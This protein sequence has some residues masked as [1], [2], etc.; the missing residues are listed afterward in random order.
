M[1]NRAEDIVETNT[2]SETTPEVSLQKSFLYSRPDSTPADSTLYIQQ[3]V[4]DDIKQFTVVGV[5]I[6][7][8]KDHSNQ[9]WSTLNVDREKTFLDPNNPTILIKSVAIFCDTL[10]IVD[11]LSLP[12][13]DIT[14]YA[15]Q[16]IL[17]KSQAINTS[18]LKWASLPPIVDASA[19]SPASN[20]LNGRNAGSFK[21]FTSTITPSS[22][23]DKYFVALGS[24][25]QNPG[26]GKDGADG[27]SA[28]YLSEKYFRRQALFGVDKGTAHFNPPAIKLKY[29]WISLNFEYDDNHTE[30]DEA[31]PENGT[32][33]LA[34]GIPGNGGNGGGLITN[35]Q[36]IQFSLDNSGGKPGITPRD[37]NG[38][39]AGTPMSWGKYYLE[40]RTSATKYD[41]DFNYQLQGSGITRAGAPATGKTASVGSTPKPEIISQAKNAW[42]HPLALQKV[43]EYSRDLFLAGEY[44]GSY[45]PLKELLEEYNVALGE[46]IQNSDVWQ[47]DQNALWAAA[48]TEIATM[49]SRLNS[50]LDYFGHPAG[51][52]PLLSL[53]AAMTMYENET[54]RALRILLLSSWFEATEKNLNK[55]RKAI[56]EAMDGLEKEIADSITKVETCTTKIND[57]L[58]QYDNDLKPQLDNKALQL[59]TLKN[60]LL[61]DATLDE[62]AKLAVKT[63]VQIAAAVCQAIPVGQPALGIAGGISGEVLITLMGNDINVIDTGSKIYSVIKGTLDAK[64]AADKALEEAKKKKRPTATK[65]AKE[66]SSSLGTVA[67]CV[68]ATFSPISEIVK[69]LQVPKAEIE[70]HLQKLES[71]SR[72]WKGLTDEIRLL[73]EQKVKLFAAL[74]EASQSLTEAWSSI[75]SSTS[76]YVSLYQDRLA[77][78]GKLDPAA[79]AFVGNMTQ[80]SRLTLLKYLYFMVKSYETTIFETIQVDWKLDTITKKIS[81]LIKDSSTSSELNLESGV[82]TLK[83]VFSE[84]LERVRKTLLEKF[85]A[86]EKNLTTFM[87]LNAKQTQEFIDQ[88]NIGRS[89]TIDPLKFS[90]VPSRVQMSKLVDIV[91]E[92]VEFE[93]DGPGLEDS[94]YFIVSVKA[95]NSGAIRK[96]SNIYSVYSDNPATWLW[97]I[98]ANEIIPALP[99]KASEDVLDFVIGKGADIIR[100][101]IAHQ[102]LWSDLTIN[103]SYFPA[104]SGKKRPCI[105]RLKF[106]LS[107]DTQL[108]DDDQC[109]LVVRST[110]AR[111]GAVISCSEDLGGRK[112]G[113]DPL[114][115]IYGINTKV[116]LEAPK[117][118][119]GSK[120][121]AWVIGEGT[122]ITDNPVSIELKESGIAECQWCAAGELARLYT[123]AVVSFL[124]IRLECSRQSEVVGFAPSIQETEI[125]EEGS[126]GWKHVHYQGAT[127]WILGKD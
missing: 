59:E 56:T 113:Y 9:L 112:A 45:M 83:S 66:N 114:V 32:D 104:Q 70:A 125:L 108:S 52:A 11:G 96:G 58:R 67:Q 2:F 44:S 101:K 16:I 75:T 25:G 92:K 23:S 105:K 14:I 10:E 107:S 64:K 103:I 7:I 77:N 51:Y 99:S 94:D 65:S 26:A 8:Q 42:L 93:S 41:I 3:F 98:S 102:P 47:N 48:K 115:R 82:N 123:D 34:P 5:H 30:L 22:S 100:S 71:E 4:D 106:K 19:S 117:E 79:S 73:N 29:Q 31:P 13:A 35:Q 116:K 95:G 27:R 80:R 119:G 120:F 78:A 110:G 81:D 15:R 1:K 111:A 40:V 118:V 72:E 17:H 122:T 38:G 88:L 61:Q 60:N 86:E 6:K 127:G 49:L 76:G 90:L 89:I 54:E 33:A 55:R 74:A 69:K 36:L 18:P 39:K 50:N 21:V 24:D 109:V 57:L 62:Y 97:T 43:I 91:L 20:G 63:S 37:Y 84:N 12:E 85:N 46:S 87:E 28:N 126:N 68:G 124:P 121:K 53:P